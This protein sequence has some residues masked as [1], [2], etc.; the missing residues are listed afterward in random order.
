VSCVSHWQRAH[1]AFGE[2]LAFDSECMIVARPI[3]LPCDR[4]SQFNQFSLVKSLTQP[5]EQWVRNFNRSTSHGIRKLQN[6]T[7][8]L[9]KIE[10]TAILVQ[11]RDLL[12]SDSICSAHGRADV[13]SKRTADQ[14]RNAQFG[15]SF[16]LV[17]DQL[18]T[19]L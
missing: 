8:Q 19:H 6:Q 10:I 11:I 16:E 5:R 15:Q 12:S 4:R 9:R 18:R 14:R 3:I 17:I 1:C 2:I 13:N 7:F